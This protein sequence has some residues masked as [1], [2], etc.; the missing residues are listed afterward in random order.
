MIDA[1]RLTTL[2]GKPPHSACSRKVVRPSARRIR[3]HRHPNTATS[4]PGQRLRR[5]MVPH[6]PP[7]TPRPH[8][9]L[10]REAAPHAARQ[11]HQP[12]QPAPAASRDRPTRTQRRRRRCSD[13][14]R[15]TD[16]TS[17]HGPSLS[18]PIGS[19]TLKSRRGSPHAALTSRD[20]WPSFVK[21]P[22][23]RLGGC[24]RSGGECCRGRTLP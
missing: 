3:D 16:R 18:A 22:V 9:H 10:E 20:R 8:H 1:S 14:P 19:A 4:T 23:S 24:W 7:R 15:P 2:A 12:L 5:T 21:L 6:A 17:S 13:P 11:V